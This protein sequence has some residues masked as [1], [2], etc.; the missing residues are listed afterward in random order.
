MDSLQQM[1]LVSVTITHQGEP[2]HMIFESA[3]LFIHI[4]PY[5]ISW[6]VDMNGV[7]NTDLLEKLQN[8]HNIHVVMQAV[9]HHGQSLVG[10]GFFYPSLK[11]A[12]ATLRGN[13]ELLGYADLE[14]KPANS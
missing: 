7:D 10:E 4:E 2:A 8:S 9:S 6:F 1:E 3:Y 12:N 14:T 11:N 13:G 5:S